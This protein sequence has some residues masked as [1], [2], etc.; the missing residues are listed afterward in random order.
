[1][2]YR[3]VGDILIDEGLIS[4]VQLETALQTQ[5]KQGGRLGNVLI[6][7]G[8]VTEEQIIVALSKQLGIPYV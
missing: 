7:L 6:K 2:K 8:Y 1:M 5:K 3:K 4:A